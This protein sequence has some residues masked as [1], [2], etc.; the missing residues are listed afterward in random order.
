MHRDVKRL[1]HN[2]R[3]NNKKISSN[4]M[5]NSKDFFTYGFDKDKSIILNIIC[6]HSVHIP[7]LYFCNKV[8]YKTGK[9]KIVST[10][11]ELIKNNGKS[12]SYD[13]IPFESDFDIFLHKNNNDEKRVEKVLLY[14]NQVFA[15]NSIMKFKQKQSAYIKTLQSLPKD[16]LRIFVTK[17]DN[18][19][20]VVLIDPWHL[21]ATDSYKKYYKEHKK[22]YIFDINQLSIE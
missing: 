8:N 14:Y 3:L 7:S 22:D 6:D 18:Q 16:E 9:N 20:N 10:I 15:E 17:N 13:K 4:K 12:V 5:Q 19:W 11:I 2:S 1:K 21:L